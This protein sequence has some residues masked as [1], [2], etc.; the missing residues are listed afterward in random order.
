MSTGAN[1]RSTI[2]P[3]NDQQEQAEQSQPDESGSPQ[4]WIP[5]V[6]DPQILM[7][8]LNEAFDYRGDVTI[9]RR[10]GSQVEG[11]I[12]DRRTGDTLDNSSVRMFP[13]GSDETVA[14][15]YSDVARLEFSGKDT[16]HG[17]SFENWIKKYIQK[18]LK[19]EEASIHDDP[20]R[21]E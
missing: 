11:Y 4:G 16:A 21:E 1:R 17:K 13:K 2:P 5:D 19:G 6:S 15:A 12:F 9:T 18:K 3:M 14:I 8:A 20:T 10:D 7:D